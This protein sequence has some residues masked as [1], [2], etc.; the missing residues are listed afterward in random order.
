MNNVYLNISK[1]LTIIFF[2]STGVI[3]KAQSTYSVNT[4]NTLHTVDEKIYGH[5][6]EH[7][8][9][10]VN[11]GLW[12]ELV[13]N[14]SLERIPGMSGEWTIEDTVIIQSSL[15]DNVRLL[16]GET[17]WTDYEITLKAQ[18]TGGDEGFLIMFR[19][20]GEN[21]YWFNIAGWGNTQHA[22][23]KG[24]PGVRW[25]VLNGLTT[26]GSVQ[27]GEWYDIRIRCEG[28]HFQT[29]IN[30]ASVFDFTD[31]EAHLTGQV[32]IGT[33]ITQAKYSNILVTAVPS[34]DTL[35]MGLP[36][37]D[38]DQEI[39]LSNWEKAGSPG[40]FANNNAL[41]SDKCVKVVNDQPSEAGIQQNDFKFENQNYN[42]SFWARG[43]S[44]GGLSVKFLSGTDVLAQQ[45][46][47]V[48]DT[49]WQ[50]Y[51]FELNP[52]ISTTNGSLQILMT[53]T[54]TVYLDQISLM[55]Q[56]AIDNDGYR[57]DLLDAVEGLKPPII[58]WP[59]GCFVS[60]YFWKDGI[61]PQ[62]ERQT[63]QIELWND[64]DVNSYGTDEFL[65]MCEKIGAEPIIV[66]NTGI[67][68]ATCGVQIT[69]KLEPEQ[70]LQDAL[71]WMEYCNGDPDTTIWGALR[72]ANG[73]REPY[74][75]KYWEIDN[76]TWSGSSVSAYNDVVKQFAPAMR[77]KYPDVKIIACGGNGF[78]QSWNYGVL[79]E[80]ADIIDYISV[81]HYENIAN[82]RTGVPS[83]ESFLKQLANRIASSAN[84]DVKIYMSEWNV[85][86]GIDWRNGLY[87]A[88]MLNV[89]E[90]QGES[91]EIG[92]PALWLRHSSANAWNN[93][94]INFNNYEWFPAPN[95]VVMK[96]WHDYYSPNYIEM[97][98]SYT[99]L[100]AVATLS[101][102]SSE[103]YFKLVNTSSS[104]QQ[105]VLDIDPS[106]EAGNV[107][108]KTITAPSL[109][110]GNSFVN[111][112]NIRVHDGRGL[113]VN[114]EAVFNSPAN[115]AMVVIVDQNPPTGLQVHESGGYVLYPNNPNP[116]NTYTTIS[117]DIP[118]PDH[119][120]LRIFDP[121]GRLIKVLFDQ[122][123][124]AGNHQTDWDGKDQRGNKVKQGIYFYEIQTSGFHSVKKMMVLH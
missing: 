34:G 11:G 82:Y 84:P 44:A 26:S 62:H 50:E 76:E 23:E 3:T 112:D 64:K 60:A 86:S 113:V 13:W 58:R 115:S 30:D 85:G 100:N 27:T 98:G 95:Y 88:G 79:N 49:V 75:V 110:S 12:G 99:D 104:D 81:H 22:I 63:Y 96:L 17:D 2:I 43:S 53:D 24:T 80:C 71:D 5:F 16:F 90:R 122:N 46:F 14:R 35:F 45:D 42:G 89:F 103:L 91:F 66:V 106:F 25:G 97:S 15:S 121:S 83:Y 21:F 19:A 47:S 1:I 6:L 52:G 29:W 117:F 124:E 32:G 28:N 92:G 74:H 116:F 93:A 101:A 119:V 40:L 123:M 68:N 107:Y 118:R 8:Y 20:E 94:L 9:N 109:L 105:I 51:T 48:P 57:P 39:T 54:G 36:S 102:D 78:D 67:L 56:D 38:A 33:W 18:K 65:Q 7:I 108:L 37:P 87:A 41:N 111:P 69:V 70:Y 55:G 4:A 120:A 72:A 10:S 114:G 31:S 61:G 77:A 59:G 73:H